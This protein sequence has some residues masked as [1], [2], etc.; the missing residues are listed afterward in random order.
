METTEETSHRRGGI[1]YYF[2]GATIHNLVINGNMSKTGPEYHGQENAQTPKSAY[3]DEV[4]ARAIMAVNGEKK[5]L[6]EKQLFLAVIKVLKYKCGWT[7]KWESACDR[8]N[9]L[10]MIKAMGLAVKCDYNNVKAPSALKFAAMDYDEWPT[11]VPSASEKELFNKNKSVGEA[12][13]EELDKQLKLARK[14]VG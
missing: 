2:E 9:D 14:E 8:I 10:P 5:P 6:C 12:F 1:Y 4:I 7:D 13:A 3:T 11:Y